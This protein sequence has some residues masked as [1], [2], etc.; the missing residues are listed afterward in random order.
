VTSM[1]TYRF[2]L[3]YHGCHACWTGCGWVLDRWATHRRSPTPLP[4]Y[5]Y[6]IAPL[7]PLPPASPPACRYYLP[8]PAPSTSPGW[9][10][11]SR[12]ATSVVDANV[13]IAGAP[14]C[15]SA[16]DLSLYISLIPPGR[17]VPHGWTRTHNLLPDSSSWTNTRCHRAGLHHMTTRGAVGTGLPSTLARQ[18]THHQCLL[19]P[20]QSCCNY[21]HCST[22]IGSLPA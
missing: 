7:L 8:P 10:G 16:R 21:G 14:G 22:Y 11:D 18:P 6:R 17:F 5:H 12:P 20:T 15:L 4:T 13:L 1:L 2:S 9:S 3:H 19:P